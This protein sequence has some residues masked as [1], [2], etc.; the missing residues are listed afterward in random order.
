MATTTKQGRLI[1]NCRIFAGQLIGV[2]Y[3]ISEL[4]EKYDKS[5]GSQTGAQYISPYFFDDQGQIRTDLEFNFGQIE[6]TFEA[7]R[8]I[9]GSIETLV[10]TLVQGAE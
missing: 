1:A 8:T 9:Q 6:A 7:L 3:D 2:N 4:L 10:S 5:G